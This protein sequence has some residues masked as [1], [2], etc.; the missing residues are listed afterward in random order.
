MARDLQRL[1]RRKDDVHYG[2]G[3]LAQGEER[4]MVEWAHRLLHNA[5]T[6]LEF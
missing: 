2:L 1:L 6:T 4:K 5:T 3:S